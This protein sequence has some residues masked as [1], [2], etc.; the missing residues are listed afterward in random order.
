[1]QVQILI[2]LL[3]LLFNIIRRRR[4]K[5]EFLLNANV[6]KCHAERSSYAGVAC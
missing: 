2:N 4:K 3:L 6:I 5:E 1:M